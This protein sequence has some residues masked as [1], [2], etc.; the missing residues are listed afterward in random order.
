MTNISVIA[1]PAPSLLGTPLCD[2]CAHDALISDYSDTYKAFNGIRPRW[3][4][5][6]LETLTNNEIYAEIN[7]LIAR[8]EATEAAY[9]A[10]KAEAKAAEARIAVEGLGPKLETAMAVALK[11]LVS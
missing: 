11:E 6:R 3:D 9:L 4:Y 10:E 8:E 2:T 1:I 5:A 7:A